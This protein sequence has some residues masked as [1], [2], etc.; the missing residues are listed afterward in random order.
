MWIKNLS[1]ENNCKIMFIVIETVSMG[2]A[3]CSSYSGLSECV[4]SPMDKDRELGTEGAV[5]GH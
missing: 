4:D 2:I 5:V 1:F 3:V